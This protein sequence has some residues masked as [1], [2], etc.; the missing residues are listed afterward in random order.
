MHRCLQSKAPKYLTDCCTPVSDIASRR[1]YVRPVDITCLYHVTS[2][3]PSAVEP[4]LLQARRSGILYRTASETRRS[5]AATSGIN[6]WLIQPLLSTLSAVEMPY[7]SALGYI[8]VRLT[9]TLT[10]LVEIFTRYIAVCR[11]RRPSTWST[12]TLQSQ[13]M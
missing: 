9:L 1:L 6:L 8:N 11:V 4:S 7:D 10:L 2:S 5:A 12:A 3:V 13:I